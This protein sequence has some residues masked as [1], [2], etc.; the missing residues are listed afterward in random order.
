MKNALRLLP[1]LLCLLTV[2]LVAASPHVAK[3]T[4]VM[5]SGSPATTNNDDS[6]D[7]GD[8]PAAT[9]LLPYFETDITS[10]ANTALDTI[11]TVTNTSRLP[12]IAHVT[13]WT[14]W[15]FPVLDF[16]LFLTGYDVQSISMYDVIALGQIAPTAGTSNVTTPG[17]MSAANSANPLLDTTNC[18]NLAKSV[19]PSILSDLRLALTAGAYPNCGSRRIGGTHANAIGYVTIDVAAVCS[20][21]LPNDPSYFA[22]ELLFDNVL[23]GDVEIINKNPAT[24]NFAGGNPLVHIRA[25]P[26]GG[27]AGTPLLGSQTN[28]PYTFYSRF[29]NGQSVG[30]TT[31]TGTLLNYDRRQPLPSVF[32]AR[33]IQGGPGAFQTNYRIWREGITGPVSCTNAVSNSAIPVSEIIR[34]DEHENPSVYSSGQIISPLPVTTVSFPE[35]STNSTSSGLFPP[36]S[37]PAGDV[38]GWMYMN[39]HSGTTAG[40]VDLVQHPGFGTRASQ[41]WVETSMFAEGR[42]G[43]DFNA[44]SLANGCTP[45]R[46]PSSVTP[47]GPGPNSTP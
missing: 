40:G 22:N 28:L 20:T 23:T 10:P 43:V 25:I 4:L 36:M 42:F 2:P 32:A 1:A 30:A 8:Y 18:G 24:G 39:L 12:Q 44:T 6:C 17:S 9:L 34:F 5:P 16:N 27:P 31:Y 38:G 19:P 21:T 13:V 37:S 41:N 14:D 47:I 15:S 11:F 46:P 33:Y 26:E 29:I 7:I 3:P 45:A 35:T